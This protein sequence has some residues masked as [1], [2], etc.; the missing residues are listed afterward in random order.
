MENQTPKKKLFVIS[1]SSGVG[2]GT[3]IQKLMKNNPHFKLSISF[4]TRKKREGEIEG[5]NYFY[6]SKDE[7]KKNVENNE[8]LEWAEFSENFY[9][10]KKEYVQKVL[11][12]GQNLI[13]EIETQGAMQVKEKMP[14]A[15]LIFILPPSYEDLE[16]RLRSRNTESEEAIAKR[17]D[18][19][20]LEI[21][22]SEKFD[23][24]VV[25]DKVES[26][27]AEIERI[28]KSEQIC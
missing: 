17:L 7:F 4:T 18:F 9:G 13:L 8:F 19:V 26:A 20:Q 27:V 5:I 6:V 10:T 24:K 15:V 22:N 14:E 23:Y 12:Q 3:V 11:N 28:I 16:N 1:G 21:K 2:K 25:N